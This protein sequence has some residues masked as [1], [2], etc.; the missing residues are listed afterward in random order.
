MKPPNVC[1]DCGASLDYNERCDCRPR[2][3]DHPQADAKAAV[4]ARIAQT[5]QGMRRTAAPRAGTKQLDVN[6]HRAEV[7]ALSY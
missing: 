3:A 6:E 5:Q 4:D 1:P 7:L 2:L